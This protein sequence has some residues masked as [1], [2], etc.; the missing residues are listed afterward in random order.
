MPACLSGSGNSRVVRLPGPRHQRP[1]SCAP[2]KSSLKHPTI[3]ARNRQLVSE[4]RR[5]GV[6]P[7]VAQ[8]TAHSGGSAI[9]ARLG[10]LL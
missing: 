3:S 8:N 1:K 6:T 2:P 5:L 9:K 10:N 7:H 4:M